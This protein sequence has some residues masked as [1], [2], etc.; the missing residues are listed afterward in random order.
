[1]RPSAASTSPPSR[2]GSRCAR[3]SSSRRSSRRS[4]A[5][6]PPRRPMC[7]RLRLR[8]T[9]IRERPR[10]RLRRRSTLLCRLPRN[11]ERLI[12]AGPVG[13]IEV[14]ID[15]PSASPRGIALV[16][17]PHPL[18]GGTLDNK[19]AHTL[20]KTFLAMGYVAT[21]FNFRGVGRSAGV[22]DEGIGET[23]D[24]L[25]VLGTCRAASASA[26]RRA[27]RILVRLVRT[28]TRCCAGDARRTRARRPRRQS[29]SAAARC[30]PRR[31]SCTARRTTSFR[32]P[33][34]SR[35]RVRRSCP[36]SCSP[37]AA[38]SSTGACCSSHAS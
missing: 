6:R 19:V 11:A 16:C 36:S 22:F 14:V 24:A 34:C 28:D 29:F 25:A 10:C 4:K 30:L 33:T 20:A 12:V 23:D 1:M 15:P 32:S 18:Q 9:P 35:G 7:P 37:A 26:A 8:P 2:A 3:S 31:S 38:I 13:D 5:V 27:R 17:H 21:R